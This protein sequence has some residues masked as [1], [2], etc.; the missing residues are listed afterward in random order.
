MNKPKIDNWE[1][2]ILKVF[3]ANNNQATLQ[4]LYSQV[5]KSITDTVSVDIQHTI[6]AYLRRLKKKKIIEQT[7]LSSYTLIQSSSKH[8]N[9]EILNLIGYGL[10]K[11]DNDFVKQFR[12]KTKSAFYTFVVDNQIAETVGTVKNRQDLF[13]PFFENGRRGWWQKGDAYIHRKILIENLFGNL[14]V[15]EYA[16]IVKLYLNENY[17]VKIEQKTKINPIIKSKFKQ[18]QI[19]GQEA[20]IFFLNNYKTISL[21]EDGKIEDARL[22]GDGYDFQIEVSPVFYLAEIKGLRTNAGS[23]RI[24]QNEFKKAKEYGDTYILSVVCNLN[25]VPKIAIVENP[26]KNLKFIPKE[27]NN[28]QITYHSQNLKW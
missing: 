22:F 19:T 27:I 11:F 26:L 20:E 6:R 1:T 10:A 3:Q 13:D 23:I 16:N 8:K 25:D 9:Y 17:S 24:T 2:A 18:L 5:P 14:N 7:G 28:K 12:F 15:S 4:I 21:F